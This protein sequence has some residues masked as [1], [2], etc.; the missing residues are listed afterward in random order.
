MTGSISE[1][2]SGCPLHDE[3]IIDF[4]VAQV[5]VLSGQACHRLTGPQ[6]VEKKPLMVYF[7]CGTQTSAHNAVFQALKHNSNKRT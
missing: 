7:P 6:T 4:T 5:P 1:C 3:A 2:N